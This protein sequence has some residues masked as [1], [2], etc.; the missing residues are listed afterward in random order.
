MGRKQLRDRHGDRRRRREDVPLS[1]PRFA[2][3]HAVITGAANGIGRATALR[4]A[5]EGASLLLL[6]IESAP[7]AA[8]AELCRGH[9]ASVDLAAGDLTQRA[10]VENAFARAGRIDILFNNVGQ[11]A[12]ERAKPF[13]ESDPDTWQFVLNVSLVTTMLVSR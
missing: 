12:R 3:R 1:T 8:T 6:D 11:S 4:F 9:G 2:G 10:V 5:Q 13:H 7:L